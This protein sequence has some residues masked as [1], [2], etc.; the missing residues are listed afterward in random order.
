MR[1][2]PYDSIKVCCTYHQLK[3]SFPN[4]SKKKKIH[5]K[6][7]TFRK[8]EDQGKRS[9]DNGPNAEKDKT[10]RTTA[11]Q[12]KNNRG[13]DIETWDQTDSFEIPD[14]GGDIRNPRWLKVQGQEESN[15]IKS[16]QIN[17]YYS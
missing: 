4:R 3:Y 15:Q 7:P 12:H 10:E 16:N 9:Q 6:E 2:V 14:K 13:G 1:P 5:T 11:L 8:M 17:L